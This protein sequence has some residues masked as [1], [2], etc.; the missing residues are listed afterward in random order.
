MQGGPLLLEVVK[1]WLDRC[2]RA[3][4][5]EAVLDQSVG[6]SGTLH[7]GPV[8]DQTVVIG[9][10]DPLVDNGTRPGVPHFMTKDGR[11]ILKRAGTVSV[12]A[13]FGKEN[14]DWIGRGILLEHV[15]TRLDVARGTTPLIGV[16]TEKV[17]TINGILAT[18]QVFLEHGTEFGDIRR[19]VPDGNWTVPLVVTVSLDITG[20]SQDI[21]SC[22]GTLLGRDDFVT[23]EDASGVVKL[24]ELIE[25]RLE[26]VKLSL[27]PLGVSLVR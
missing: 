3:L 22:G 5:S 27:S 8:A 26:S 4:A 11:L 20:R 21:G 13:G 7:R 23:D 16:Q 25:D 10:L 19:R 12:A 14:G 2:R 24:L 9:L 1:V 6:R 15:V 18:S 17:E